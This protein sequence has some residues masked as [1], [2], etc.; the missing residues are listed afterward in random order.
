MR[1]VPRAAQGATAGAHPRPPKIDSAHPPLCFSSLCLW[2]SDFL[3]AQS[4]QVL[5][6]HCGHGFHKACI[7]RWLKTSEQPSC[8]ICK[9]PALSK[10]DPE[11][12]NECVECPP[13]EG[14]RATTA[15]A[16]QWWHT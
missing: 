12:E 10:A 3:S 8:P 13:P 4:L 16:E 2:L 1:R 15:E 7:V 14:Y 6:L 11:E 5:T 9:A